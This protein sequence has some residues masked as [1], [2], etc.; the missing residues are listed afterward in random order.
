MKFEQKI[1]IT[2]RTLKNFNKHFVISVKLESY[3]VIFETNF[4]F[5]ESSNTNLFYWLFK[6]LLLKKKIKNKKE[7]SWGMKI[8]LEILFKK[9]RFKVINNFYVYITFYY[10]LVFNFIQCI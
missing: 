7:I 5:Q 9:F 10:N 4:F 2:V 1:E 8:N 3:L 6:K